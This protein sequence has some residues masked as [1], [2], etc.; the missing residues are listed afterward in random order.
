MRQF[1]GWDQ[2]DIGV[3]PLEVGREET[4]EGYIVFVFRSEEH[5]L[6][7]YCCRGSRR[8]EGR[9]DNV[10]FASK[11]V[12]SSA[13]GVLLFGSDSGPGFFVDPVVLVQVV[14][15]TN[16]DDIKEWFKTLEEVG[17][18]SDCVELLVKYGYGGFSI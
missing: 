15:N 6:R 16:S 13:L 2:S 14:H 5:D 10:R 8:V 1:N 11:G 3:N 4:W 9:E 17:V 7:E 12:S 18:T